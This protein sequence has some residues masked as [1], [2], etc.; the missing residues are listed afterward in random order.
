MH[1]FLSGKYRQVRVGQNLRNIHEDRDTPERLDLRPRPDSLPSNNDDNGE[2]NRDEQTYAG[3]GEKYRQLIG[4]R[5]AQRR[6]GR[7]SD[8]ELCSLLAALEALG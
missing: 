6:V 7:I 3:A 5:R 2:S 1:V 4:F 8:Y